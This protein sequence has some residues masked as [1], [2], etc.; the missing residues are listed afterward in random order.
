MAASERTDRGDG[1]WTSRYFQAPTFDGLARGQAEQ[2]QVPDWYSRQYAHNLNLG[3][4]IV[5]AWL[6]GGRKLVDAW[7]DSVRSQQDILLSGVRDQME[8][9]AQ[10][11]EQSASDA[12]AISAPS[13]GARRAPRTAKQPQI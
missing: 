1:S 9:N 2:F 6:M 10:F 7:R 3:I 8:T 12:E 13:A 5:Q 11:S 4:D